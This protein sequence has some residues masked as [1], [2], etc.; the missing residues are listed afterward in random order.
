MSYSASLAGSPLCCTWSSPGMQ[1][2]CWLLL[3]HHLFWHIHILMRAW[4]DHRGWTLANASTLPCRRLWQR[5]WVVETQFSYHEI[6]LTH[7][8]LQVLSPHRTTLRDIQTT[9]IVQTRYKFSKDWSWNFNL[10]HSTSLTV[11]KPVSAITWQSWTEMERPWSKKAVAR[12]LTAA[13]WSEAR[14]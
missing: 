12:P 5:R 7:L 9:L 8:M 10:L 6:T 14:A 1:L 13:L 3:L 11:L 4:L 2:H